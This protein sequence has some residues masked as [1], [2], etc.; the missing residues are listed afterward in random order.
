M[1]KLRVYEVAKDLGLENKALV[2]LFQSVGVADVRN[3]MSVVGLDSVERVKRLIEK[4]HSS[5]KSVEERIRPT[6]VKRRAAPRPAEAE[7]P[8]QVSPA[9]PAPEVTRPAVVVRRPAPEVAKAPEVSPAVVQQAPVAAAPV[10]VAPTVAAV[11]A[12]AVVSATKVAPEPQVAEVAVAPEVSSVAAPEKSQVAAARVQ[13]ESAPAA[14]E[15]PAPK[16]ESAAEPTSQV[17]QAEVA[18]AAPATPEALQ[19]APAPLP[20]IPPPALTPSQRPAAPKTG[21]DVW[22][23]RPGVPMPQVHRST[24]PVARR[25]QYDAKAGNIGGRPRGN[26]PMMGGGGMTGGAPSG[27][28]GGSRGPAQRGGGMRQRGLGSLGR[29]KGMGQA[30]TQERSAHKKVVRVEESVLLQTLAGKM[31]I[32]ATEVLMKLMRLGMTGVNIN[33]TLDAETAKIVANEFGWEVEDV[34]VSEEDAIV[35][36]QGIETVEDAGGVPRPPVVTVMGHVDHGK[37]SLLDKIRQASVASGEAG[38]ITQHIGAYTVQTKHGTVAFLDTPGHEAFTAMRAR[39]AQATDIVILVVAADDGVMPQTLEAISH[40]RAAKVPILVAVNKCDKPDAQPERVR[41]ELSDVGL[42]PEEWGGDTLFAEVSAMTGAG[43]EGLLDQVTLLA[44]MLELKANPD[45]PASGVVIEAQLDRGRGPVATVLITDGTLRRGDVIL[46]GGAFGKTRAMLNSARVSVDEAGPS[47]PVE[48]IGLNDVPS[49]GD[50]VYVIRDMKTAQALAET[51][52]VKDRRSLGPSMGGQ[53]MSLEELAKAMSETDRLDLKVI[54]KADVQGSVEA[55]TEAIQKLATPKVR[56]SVVHVGVGGITEGD[57]NLAIASGAIIIGFNARPAGKASSLAQQEKIEIRQYS[58]IYN[59]V[60]DI[61]A[62][63]E[64]LLAPTLVEK[65]IGRAEVR[66]TFRITKA[67]TVAGCMVVDGI[68]KRNAG[69]RLI[70]E[71]D[72]L[73]T[74]KATTLKR[75]KDDVRDVKEGFECGI[76]LDGF[77]DIKEGDIIEAFEMEEIKQ[78]L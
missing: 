76:S 27:S 30:V 32:K 31:Q 78:T 63:M 69:M 16:V 56:V 9:A 55:L 62:A 42:L 29:S 3:H 28:G 13:A 21:I 75:F 39:G 34:T 14:V 58:I 59:V 36:A 7:T 18:E 12:E 67:G 45:K 19:V 61:R 10:V 57:V 72:V 74:G 22:G 20:A 68:I 50:P 52:K 4:Q 2:A 25:V 5:E 46:A 26:A 15:P 40:A 73:F 41:R 66:Q 38:G 6:V 37:T 11:P 23:G 43:I 51:R 47:T 70:R 77:N 53:R 8:A 54:I 71:K 49:A 64:G 35:A 48:I 24:G 44:E 33:S 1:S 65:I 17:V 60:D